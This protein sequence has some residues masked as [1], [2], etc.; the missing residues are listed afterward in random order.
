MRWLIG[1]ALLLTLPLSAQEA[2]PGENPMPDIIY[3][4]HQPDGNRYVSGRGS[5]PDVAVSDYALSL[6]P[7]VMVGAADN[8]GARWQAQAADGQAQTLTLAGNG[9]Q[10]GPVVSSPRGAP[11]YFITADD[12]A[13]A[14]FRSLP[15]ASPLAPPLYLDDALV[16]VARD[17]ALVLWADDAVRDRL[18]L[19]IQPDARL[20]VN[21]AGQVAVY[22]LA[23]NQRYVHA[24]MGDDLEGSALVVVDVQGSGLRLLARVDLPGED[25][26]EGL[27]PLWA[28]VDGDGRADLVTTVSNGRDGARNRV[29]LFDGQ[30]IQREVDG[31]PI[32]RGGRW[33][34]QL[35][36]GPFGPA[37]EPLLVDVL[38]PH[39]GG[40]VRFH[41]YTG[42]GLEIIA[43]L[44]GY[45]SH[46][47]YERNLDMAVAGDFNGDGVPEIALPSQDRATVAGVQLTESGPQVVWSLPVEG[48]VVGNLVVVDVPG[49]GLALAITTDDGR[50][51]LWR[52][53]AGGV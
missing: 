22:A 13:R 7:V 10:L 5:F 49:E 4:H 38:T 25:V 8:A 36:W 1:F 12:A 28:D 23:T 52:S 27:S 18:P 35:A 2:G 20:V 14:R 29:Y 47:I 30:R 51:R 3:P 40:V 44:P 42:N 16:Y 46:V 19:N 37:G 39:I 21:D 31:P 41:R 11:D 15:D 50:L 33:Q 6:T 34:H 9:P 48:R 43:T 53:Q 45:T 32:G 17:G 26:Y 24:I